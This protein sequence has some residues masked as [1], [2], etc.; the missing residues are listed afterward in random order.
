MSSPYRSSPAGFA[1][2][3][4]A[5]VTRQ[6]RNSIGWLLLAIP[7]V[8]SFAFFVGDYATEALAR[9]PGSLPFGRFA[10]WVDRWMIIPTL[11]L[12]I[13]FFLLFPEG[14][15]PSRRWRPVL[16]LTIACPT[17]AIVAFALTPVLLTGAFA[18]LTTV[19]VMNPLGIESLRGVLEVLTQV[20]GF[21]SLGAAV[22]AGAAIELRYRSASGEVRQQIRWLALVGVAFLAEFVVGLVA[23][24]L[25]GDS[26][27]AGD[28]LFLALF[29]TLALGIPLA[30]GVAILR[31]RLYDLDVVVR[32]AVVF[33]AMAMFITAVYALL[34]GGVGAIVGSRGSTTLSF[35]AAAVLAVGFQPARD[36]ARRFADRVVYGKARH[37]DGGS[38]GRSRWTA[39][40]TGHP[41]R[42]NHDRRHPSRRRVIVSAGGRASQA[43]LASAQASSKRSGPKTAFGM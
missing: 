23:T 38:L 5:I 16:W 12:F 36:R 18:D 19:R 41:G 15:I 2:V 32:K 43:L 28:L 42:R 31:Y 29:L 22:L 10:G 7:L 35:V 25:N 4:W 17:V 20:G 37:A 6:P 40:G 39:P 11:V 3:G 14:R 13:P 33:G 8:A 9:N 27:I 1:V 24:A 26:G 34:V 30:C 21:S